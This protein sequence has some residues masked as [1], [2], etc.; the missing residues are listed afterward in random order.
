MA[1]DELD[2]Q[3][4]AL[5]TNIT[6][7][8]TF[9]DEL[10]DR[11]FLT[12]AVGDPYDARIAQTRE[13]EFDRTCNDIEEKTVRLLTLQ[14]PILATDL[15]LLVGALVVAQRLQRV[16]HGA[17]GIAK[18]A[19]ELT[20]TPTSHDAAPAP[21]LALG[22][23]ARSA[24]TAAV[25]AFV[26][27]RIELA[28]QVI[29]NEPQIDAEYRQQRDDY[30]SRLSLPDEPGKENDAGLPRK[31]TYWLW[32]AHKLERVADHAVVIARRVQQLQ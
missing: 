27:E 10:L 25:T 30:I 22:K 15:R 6:D 31:I 5:R 4:L 2:R 9:V 26:E 8:C 1:R 24:L 29:N 12:L 32:I 23:D 17:F 19:V 16:G 18:L 21:L 13:N 3:L 7:L 11:A 20:D 14:Q 28:Q